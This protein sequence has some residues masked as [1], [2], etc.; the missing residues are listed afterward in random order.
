ML[1]YIALSGKIEIGVLRQVQDRVFVGCG[2][3][4]QPQAVIV[5]QRIKR[6]HRKVAG[7]AFFTILAQIFQLE[8][9]PVLSG[10]DAGFPNNL[11]EAFEAAM[12]RVWSIIDGQLV[13]FAV[14]RELAPGDAVAITANQSS[15]KR[16]VFDVVIEMIVAKHNVAHFSMA[17]G[18][19]K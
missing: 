3:V 15:E 11:V 2:S 5:G 18:R 13:L 1:Q 10:S 17:I 19:L 14:E 12:E 16:I 9:R 8:R 6:G 4:I 7:V